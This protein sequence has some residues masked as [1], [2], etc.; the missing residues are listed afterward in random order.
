MSA[1]AILAAIAILLVGLP[2]GRVQHRLRD[3]TG[4]SSHTSVSLS[5]R[6][7]L[8]VGLPLGGLAL[9]GVAGLSAAGIVVAVVG[10]RQARRRRA[11]DET[12]RRADLI[13]ALTLMGSELSVGAP[14][15]RACA[16]AAADLADRA[17]AEATET[18]TIATGLAALAARAELGGSVAVVD[19]EATT[20]GHEADIEPWRPVASAWRSAEQH[21]LPLAELLGSLRADLAARQAFAART[22]AGLAGPRATSAVLAG[23]PLLGI[24]LGQATGA[25]PIGV[26]AGGGLGAI[27]LVIG[28]AL[29][30]AGV[31]WSERITDKAVRA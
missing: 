11:R 23:L 1:A 16:A 5:P 18:T 14:P 2:R 19:I 3:V 27:L 10:W 26:L 13:V 8:F 20:S 21:G 7:L 29:A 17:D 30:G 22:Q 12:R 6:A 15:A 28:T 31:V 24:A 25:D 4:G 9:A